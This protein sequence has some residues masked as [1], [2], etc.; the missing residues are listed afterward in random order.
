MAWDLIYYDM[1]SLIKNYLSYDENRGQDIDVVGGRAVLQAVYGCRGIC[2]Y[3]MSISLGRMGY[4]S[5][6]SANLCLE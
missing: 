6:D 5:H 2:M 1:S 3:S 4:G